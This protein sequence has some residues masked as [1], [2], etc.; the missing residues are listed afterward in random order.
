[1]Y[2]RMLNK[3]EEPSTEEMTA[4]CG[5]NGKRFTLLN[6]W[7]TETFHTEQRIVF[8]Y[9]NHYGWCISHKMKN[10]LICNIFAEDNVFTVMMRLSDRQYQTVYSQLQE[11]ARDLIDNKYPCGN[12]GWIQ[13]RVTGEE[14]FDDIKT[15]LAVKCTG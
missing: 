15:L 1:M 4:F 3:R 7:L 13:Y 10:K 11:Y 9:G 14:Q 6:K 2:E 8:P 5:E 12:G